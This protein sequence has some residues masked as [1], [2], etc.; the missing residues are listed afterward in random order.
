[1]K[2][3]LDEIMR[4]KIKIIAFVIL[5]M[6]I[7]GILF[8]GF[9]I[10]NETFKGLTNSTPREV[11][12]KNISKYKKNYEKFAKDKDV[13]EIKIKSSKFEHEIPAIFV[14]NN[15]SSKICVMVHGMGASKYSMYNPGQIFYDLGYSLLIYDQRNS[16]YNKAKYSTFGVL[17]SFDAL[18]CIKYVRKNIKKNGEIA[19]FG[20]SYGAASSLIAA[21]RDKSNIDY[22]ILDCPV[23]DSNYFSDKVFE[24]IEKDQKIPASIM[25]FTGNIFLKARLGFTLEDINTIKWIKGEKLDIPTLIINSDSDTITPQYMGEDIYKAIDSKDKEIYTAKSYDHI[26]F[27][28]ENPQ[29]YK[30]VINDFLDKNKK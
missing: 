20:E 3:R 10:G 12:V 7:F 30:K 21:S 17:E 13:E 4:K 2:L 6:L 29:D 27:C 8:L 28:E 5:T 15:N 23:S 26:K 14:K 16:G 19:L 18:D 1:M 25:K 9:F 11:T 22:L 24:K